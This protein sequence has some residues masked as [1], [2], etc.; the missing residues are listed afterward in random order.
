[1]LYAKLNIDYLN[2]IRKE[3]F[4]FLPEEFLQNTKLGYIV[5]QSYT[6]SYIKSL[7]SIKRLID[8]LELSISDI[9]IC[10]FTVCLPGQNIPI[11]I[12]RGFYKLSLNIPITDTTGTV[13]NFYKLTGSPTLVDT[14][15]NKYISFDESTTTIVET[16][17][18]DSPCIIDTTVPHKVVNNT[19]R[20]RV[21]LLIRFKPNIKFNNIKL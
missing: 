6:T 9:S 13:V 17:D 8:S 11:H 5:D 20:T 21:M 4:D 15:K 12:D 16:L 10:A 19:D 14:G 18:T 1:M 7:S 2:E 3:V